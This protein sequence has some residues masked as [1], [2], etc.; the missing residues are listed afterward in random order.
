MTTSRTDR[1]SATRADR[2][3]GGPVTSSQ[4]WKAWILLTSL[5]ATVFGWIAIPGIKVPTD[6]VVV[7]PRATTTATD[8][9]ASPDNAIGE[10]L[11][12]GSSV[13]SLPAMP[14][15]PGF[16]APVTRTRRS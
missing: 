16:Q 7:Q 2:G 15:K 9:L 8:V 6:R 5:A 1:A 4:W 10:P 14:Q 13:R 12:P 3:R 11:R